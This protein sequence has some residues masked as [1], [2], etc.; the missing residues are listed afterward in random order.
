MLCA[1]YFQMIVVDPFLTGKGS[2]LRGIVGLWGEIINHPPTVC[3]SATCSSPPYLHM[4]SMLMNLAQVMFNCTSWIV[5][6]QTFTV[7]IFH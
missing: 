6:P 4:D 1:L 2:D 5:A 7:L 3:L